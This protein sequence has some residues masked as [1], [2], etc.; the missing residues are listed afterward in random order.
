MLTIGQDGSVSDVNEEAVRLTG[1][2][3]SELVSS[4]FASHFTDPERAEKGVRQTLKE[5]IVRDFDLELK[6]KDGTVISLSFSARPYLEAEGKV[7][8][9][10]AIARAR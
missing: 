2:A 4:Q 10:F 8:G 3:R 5:G 7:A 1:R 9:I 6:R